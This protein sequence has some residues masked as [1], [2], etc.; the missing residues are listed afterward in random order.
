MVLGDSEAQAAARSAGHSRGRP[1]GRDRSRVAERSPDR[2]DRSRDRPAGRDPGR[3]HRSRDPRSGRSRDRG[4]GHPV[5]CNR[6]RRERPSRGRLAVRSRGYLAVRSR[7]YL[8][9]RSRGRLPTRSPGYQAVRCRVRVAAIRRFLARAAVGRA[10]IEVPD[11]ADLPDRPDRP[12]AAAGGHPATVVRAAA[13]FRGLG[14]TGETGRPHGAQ[15]LGQ[16]AGW[17]SRARRPGRP[18]LGE[19]ETPD[20]NR[21][22]GAGTPD[23]NRPRGAG[24]PDRNRPRGAGTPDRNRP[25]GAGTPGRNR[26]HGAGTPD[27]NRPRGAGTRG[28]SRRGEAEQLDRVSWRSRGAPVHRAAWV[29]VAGGCPGPVAPSRVLPGASP[30]GMGAAEALPLVLGGSGIPGDPAARNSRVLPRT[31]ACGRRGECRAGPPASTPSSGS[32]PV[33]VPGERVRQ[34]PGRGAPPRPRAYRSGPAP[35]RA[36]RK[37]RPGAGGPPGPGTSPHAPSA[38]WT[39]CTCR[40]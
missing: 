2:R 1:A 10:R 17:A 21:P 5:G 32:A 20:R 27:R 35:G 40:P 29:T 23:R 14:R 4:L 15:R 18:P 33:P 28:R 39:T 11:R 31:P 38:A 13:R 3:R 34:H 24:T 37:P 26:R 19:G 25:R 8:A 7:G 30:A 12:R 16:V 22:R 9:V 36:H 6:H